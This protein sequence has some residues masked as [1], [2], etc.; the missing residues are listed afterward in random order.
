VLL[1]AARLLQADRKWAEAR[2]FLE[3]ALDQSDP[4]LVTEA[5]YRLGEGLRDAGQN[6]EAVEA[7]MT[8]AYVAPDSI[9]G[10]R[11]LLAAGQSFDALR[12]TEAAVI[13][14]KK[15]LAASDLEPELAETA[16][17]RLKALGGN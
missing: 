13:V 11:A 12:Q 3:R 2:G 4:G 1:G 10:R 9:W 16:R 14:Y 6:E 8:A 17:S 7:Y 5:A 15:L